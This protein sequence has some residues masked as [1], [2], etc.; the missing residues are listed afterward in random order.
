[1]FLN[2]LESVSGSLGRGDNLV[3]SVIDRNFLGNVADYGEV[4]E[5]GCIVVPAWD[6][7]FY[8]STMEESQLAWTMTLFPQC[9]GK[10]GLSGLGLPMVSSSGLYIFPPTF[11]RIN[12][13]G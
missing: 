3:H 1:M 11:T 13:F 4:L 5:I 2:G 7:F 8:P 10:Y 12:N 9:K 6:E